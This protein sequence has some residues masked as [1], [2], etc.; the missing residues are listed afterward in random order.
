M[1]A[2]DNRV[3]VWLYG[4]LRRFATQ[5]EV[6]GNS[7]VHVLVEE[8]DTIEAVMRR[9]GINLRETS[10]IFLNGELSLP[11]RQVKGGDRLGIFP[12]DQALLY[13][14]YFEKKE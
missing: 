1:V 3:E 14:W 8:G 5:R 9:I 6:A 7:I 10:N 13:K 4:K 12:S 2:R 11:A